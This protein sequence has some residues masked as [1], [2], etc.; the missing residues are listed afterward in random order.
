MS[1]SAVLERSIT[2]EVDDPAPDPFDEVAEGLAAGRGRGRGR[3]LSVGISK[4]WQE[5]TGAL[6]D[7]FN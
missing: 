7:G 2:L 4:I 5:A 3:G 1:S 6:F